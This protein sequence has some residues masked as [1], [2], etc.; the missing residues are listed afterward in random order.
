MIKPFDFFFDFISPYSYLAHEQI[1]NIELQNNI[2]INYI[3]V[4]LGGLLKM[5]GTKANI[6]IPSKAKFMIRDCKLIA[7]DISSN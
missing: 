3:P 2:K 4:L 6:F 7:E 5:S 1:K